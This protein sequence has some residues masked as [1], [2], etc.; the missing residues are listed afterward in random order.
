MN[1]NRDL[2]VV[3]SINPDR[4][5]IGEP[6]NLPERYAHRALGMKASE[7]RSLF[8]VASRPEIVCSMAVDK[9]IQNYVSKFV[10]SWHLK[11]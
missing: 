6:E 11:E 8:A 5:H 9:V 3:K 2:R 4:V 10:M 7:I 1:S